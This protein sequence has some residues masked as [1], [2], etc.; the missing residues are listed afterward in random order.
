LHGAVWPTPL[1]LFFLSLGLGFLYQR[2]GGIVA[3]IALHMIFNGVSTLMMFLVLGANPAPRP[4]DPIPPPA[5]AAVL[6]GNNS[7]GPAR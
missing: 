1:P 3:P 6:I 2:T 7:G 4:A 5:A